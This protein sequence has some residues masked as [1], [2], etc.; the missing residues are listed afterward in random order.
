MGADPSGAIEFCT[1]GRPAIPILP[2]DCNAWFMLFIPEWRF[3]GGASHG[4]G[5]FGSYVSQ[6]IMPAPP[7]CMRCC[8]RCCAPRRCLEPCFTVLNRG[9]NAGT[10]LLS[11]DRLLGLLL[12]VCGLDEDEDD[13]V[14]FSRCCV[15][16][17]SGFTPALIWCAS[18]SNAASLAFWDEEVSGA[19]LPDWCLCDA[20]ATNWTFDSFNLINFGFP[21]LAFPVLAFTV[22]AFTDDCEAF[23]PDLAATRS[24]GSICAFIFSVSFVSRLQWRWTAQIYPFVTSSASS[25]RRF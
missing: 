14:D 4:G 11:V 7:P 3:H 20:T 5:L 21:V 18:L 16:G 25:P 15:T 12:D 17:C 22:L 19:A 6:V 1:E 13:E 24:G 9:I 8:W 10:R 2:G 23:V